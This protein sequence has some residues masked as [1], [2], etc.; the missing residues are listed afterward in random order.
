MS[1]ID[2]NFQGCISTFFA[3]IERRRRMSQLGKP[4]LLASREK[5]LRRQDHD[6]HHLTIQTAVLKFYGFALLEKT[7]PFLMKLVS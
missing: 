3:I 6:Q 5:Y 4:A 2:R 1:M 7:I